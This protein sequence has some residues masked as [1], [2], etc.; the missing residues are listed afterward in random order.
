MSRKGDA[1]A[2]D[3][4]WRAADISSVALSPD[5]AELAVAVQEGAATNLWIKRLNQGPAR[6]LTFE[7]DVNARPAWTPDGRAVAFVSNGHSRSNLNLDLYVAP[8]D[9]SAPPRMLRDEPAGIEEA[10]YSRDGKWLVYQ[11]GFDLFAVRTDRDASPIRLTGTPFNESTP[12]LSPDGRWL[13]Y[14]SDES[15]RREVYVRPFPNTGTTRWQVSAGGGWEP[16]WSRSGGELFYNSGYRLVAAT[17]LPGATFG[18][19]D[20]HVLFSVA[21]YEDSWI[22][23]T[24]DVSPDGRRFVM[25]RSTKKPRDDLIVVENGF[26]ELKARVKR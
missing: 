11:V 14:S 10:E 1:T 23:R 6:K 15:R 7:G 24:Y 2:I 13:A 25:I 17:V 19:R 16:A 22:Q 3:T 5:G 21:E 12:R 18:V 8:A 26:E 20:R 9:G 4:A